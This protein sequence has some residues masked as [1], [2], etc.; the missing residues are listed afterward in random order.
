MLR[1]TTTWLICW[2]S[3]LS[4]ASPLQAQT[5]VPVPDDGKSSGDCRCENHVVSPETYNRLEVERTVE[6]TKVEA[7]PSGH[8]GLSHADEWPKRYDDLYRV[9]YADSTFEVDVQEGYKFGDFLLGY[10]NPGFPVSHIHP[11]AIA[12]GEYVW[13]TPKLPELGGT[14]IG[15]RLNGSI[16]VTGNASIDATVVPAAFCYFPGMYQ[17]PI[18]VI[19]GFHASSSPTASINLSVGYPKRHCDGDFRELDPRDI[20]RD[21]VFS[22]TCNTTQSVKSIASLTVNG[23]TKRFAED[24]KEKDGAGMQVK[25]VQDVGASATLAETTLACTADFTGTMSIVAETDSARISIPV[26][27]AASAKGTATADEATATGSASASAAVRWSGDARA[28]ALPD[29]TII[30]DSGG[31]LLGTGDSGVFIP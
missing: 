20:K 21:I 30:T 24:D 13:K 18:P 9:S 19:T 8:G 1:S 23:E 29:T 6:V 16:T 27:L 14:E 3:I 4:V 11:K 31:G 17:Y 7:V 10:T 12:Q 22:G 15:I 2:T 28:C 5:L 26:A 25:S